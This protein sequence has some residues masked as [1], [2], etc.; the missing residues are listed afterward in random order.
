MNKFDSHVLLFEKALLNVSLISTKFL[1][2]G[3][4]F[5]VNGKNTVNRNFERKRL[6]AYFSEA[7]EIFDHADF[8]AEYRKGLKR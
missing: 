5:E 3:V 8:V 4:A 6:I 7:N 2:K 1:E